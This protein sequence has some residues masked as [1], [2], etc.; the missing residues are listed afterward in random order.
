MKRAC[1]GLRLYPGT[2][3]EYDRRHSA[4]WPEQQAAIK[5]AGIR[6]MSGF[7]RGTD[8]WYYAECQPDAKTAFAKL[9]ASKAN[10]TWNASFQTIIAELTQPDGERISFEEIFHANG[11]GVG[12]FERGLFALVVHPDRLAEYDRRHAEPWPEMMRAL[13]K[14]GFHNYSGFRRDSQVVYYGEFH[15]GMATAT[16]AIGATDVNRRWNVS[17]QGIITTITDASGNLLTAREIFHQ[18]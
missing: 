17:F 7:R 8:V 16:G 12:P 2:E 6:N 11:G 18:D 9:G 1:F 13:D 5:D 3:T 14:A 4:I 15:P 10:A